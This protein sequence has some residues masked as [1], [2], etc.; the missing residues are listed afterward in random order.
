MLV[1]YFNE[2]VGLQLDIRQRN[3]NKIE[4]T[5]G[6]LPNKQIT[7]TLEIEEN[8]ENLIEIFDEIFEVI[9]GIVDNHMEFINLVR[10]FLK[11]KSSFHE[12]RSYTEW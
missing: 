6:K 7:L 3:N 12:L 2:I 1:R 4:L 8:K 10:R 9:D 5:F 11:K